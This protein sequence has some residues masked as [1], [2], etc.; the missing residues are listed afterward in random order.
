MSRLE[1]FKPL[2]MLK[3][4]LNPVLFNEIGIKYATK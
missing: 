2:M 4:K 3:D 1:S